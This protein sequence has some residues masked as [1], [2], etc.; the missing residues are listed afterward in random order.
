MSQP[1]ELTDEM[2]EDLYEVMIESP[3]WPNEKLIEAIMATPG[4]S[5]S[6]LMHWRR[7]D[8]IGEVIDLIEEN[9]NGNALSV[10]AGGMFIVDMNKLREERELM[11]VSEA[12]Q[13]PVDYAAIG[14]MASGFSVPETLACLREQVAD[15]KYGTLP[16]TFKT[17][18]EEMISISHDGKVSVQAHGSERREALMEGFEGLGDKISVSRQKAIKLV[19]QI[20]AVNDRS[21]ENE[22]SLSM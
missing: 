21:V 15:N 1:H 2:R 8:L 6:D 10:D 3:R 4:L 14:C 11:N 20:G 19:S 22:S 5:D 9:Y 16:E 17:P 18:N 12:Q 13:E 7:E